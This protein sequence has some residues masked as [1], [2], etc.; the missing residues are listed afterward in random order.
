MENVALW[1]ERDIS[2]SSVERVALPD[3]TLLLDYALLRVTA[4]VDNLVVNEE[5][6]RANLDATKGLVYSQ[7]VLLT[8][9]EELGLARDEA[10]R[11]VQR[12]AMATWESMDEPETLRDH[13]A[14]DPDVDL[15][16]E[17]LDRCFSDERFIANIDVVFERLK[18]IE[19]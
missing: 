6:M 5:R 11:L 1:H 17:T 8:L 12:S 10:Y 19:L 9:I 18:P 15:S 4:L 2:H 7:A 14:A 13:L 16:A 3:A